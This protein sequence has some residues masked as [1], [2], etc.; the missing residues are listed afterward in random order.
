MILTQIPTQD[1]FLYID[2]S[3]KAN[4]GEFNVFYDEISNPIIAQSPPLN[5]DVVTPAFLGIPFL[6]IPKIEHKFTEKQI[7]GVSED[8]AEAFPELKKMPCSISDDYANVMDTFEELISKYLRSIQ[9]KVRVVVQTEIDRNDERTGERIYKPVI[10]EKDG[11]SYLNGTIV[12][13][14]L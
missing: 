1:G 14:Y 10:Y 5:K 12:N 7:L 13:D 2:E 9:K 6:V 4:E 3:R 8:I 11:N